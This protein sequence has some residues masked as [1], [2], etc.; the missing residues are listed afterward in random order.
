MIAV[1]GVL[2][3]LLAVLCLLPQPS[4][5]APA[6]EA[7]RAVRRHWPSSDRGGRSRRGGL[8]SRTTQAI[9]NAGSTGASPSRNDSD[10]NGRTGRSQRQASCDLHPPDIYAG[11]C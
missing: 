11:E 10:P 7:G 3:F 1:R 2:P 9:R 6:A 8:P 5:E 4:R